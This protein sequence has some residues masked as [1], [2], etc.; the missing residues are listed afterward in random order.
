[1]PSRD[2]PEQAPVDVLSDLLSEPAVP[3]V[4]PRPR[5]GDRR[6]P[7]PAASGPSLLVVR[8]IAGAALSVCAVALGIVGLHWTAGASDGVAAVAE[9]AAAALAPSPLPSP[10]AAP[11]AP[12]RPRC[13]RSRPRPSRRPRASP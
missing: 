1:M 2:A 6:R 5:P 11:P 3:S 7:A 13:C 4:A 10:A 8:A 9:T 12:L